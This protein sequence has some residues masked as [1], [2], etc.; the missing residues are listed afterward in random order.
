MS[1]IREKIDQAVS[2]SASFPIAT[3]SLFKK[4]VMLLLH[5]L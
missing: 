1:D 5:E 3:H 2:E 4:L